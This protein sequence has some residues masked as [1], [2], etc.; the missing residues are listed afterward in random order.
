M[1]NL[2]QVIP[3]EITGNL[4]KPSKLFAKFTPSFLKKNLCGGEIK[5]D[6]LVNFGTGGNVMCVCVWGGGGGVG[7]I[8]E[9]KRKWERFC[10]IR[11]VILFISA[12]LFLK[13]KKNLCMK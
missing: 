3:R 9:R 10:I 11:Y 12:C 7:R 2:V 1:Q 13:K 4:A 5:F 8:K 6:S